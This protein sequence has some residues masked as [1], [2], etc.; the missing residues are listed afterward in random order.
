MPGI[1]VSDGGG[2]YVVFWI[3]GI[4]ANFIGNFDYCAPEGKDI[5]VPVLLNYIF[6]FSG[7]LLLVLLGKGD[8]FKNLKFVFYI[9]FGLEIEDF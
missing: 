9:N 1:G 2:V 7:D 4:L 8:F 6:V 5:A 3:C